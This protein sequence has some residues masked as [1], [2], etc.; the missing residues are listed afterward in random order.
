MNRREAESDTPENISLIS[1]YEML[2]ML[3]NWLEWQQVCGTDYGKINDVSLLKMK[4]PKASLTLRQEVYSQRNPQ[5]MKNAAGSVH[6]KIPEEFQLPNS[7]TQEKNID[8]AQVNKKS[9]KQLVA[10]RATSRT[11]DQLKKQT[12][13]TDWSRASKIKEYIDFNQYSPSPNSLQQVDMWVKSNCSNNSVRN[14]NTKSNK[15]K[16]ESCVPSIG[17]WEADVLLIE[18]HSQTLNREGLEMLKKMRQNVLL[19]NAN[20]FFWL[21]F[22]RGKGCG[23]CKAVFK[24]KLNSVKPKIVLWMGSEL[25]KYL[26]FEG[27]IP[28]HGQSGQLKMIHGVVPI[29]RSYHPMSLLEQP[30]LKN[31]AHRQL[32]QFHQLLLRAMIVPRENMARYKSN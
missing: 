7:N 23:G 20:Q 28:E 15:N 12:L 26:N 31:E 19:I 25:T 22:P 6:Q 14:N 9:S 24:A 16:G 4:L 1:R 3:E 10:N 29:F 13:R 27:S 18:G 2:L 32:K 5:N 30:H 21:P 8:D 17:N 11:R